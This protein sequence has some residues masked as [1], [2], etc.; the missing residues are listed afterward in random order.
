VYVYRLLFYLFQSITV[1][2]I[3]Q[4]VNIIYFIFALGERILLYIYIMHVV[5]CFG[6]RKVVVLSNIVSCQCSV[7]Y[8]THGL[9]WN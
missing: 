9:S 8:F 5:I 2:S 1:L 4:A 6:H 7:E 3:L